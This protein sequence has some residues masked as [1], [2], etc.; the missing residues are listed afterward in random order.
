[1][2]VRDALGPAA[3]V[4]DLRLLASDIDTD[5]LGRA[6]DGVY[7]E[8][9]TA[10]IPSGLRTRYV[11]RG[12]GG[13]AGLVCIRPEIRALVTFRR[14]NLMDE[15]WPIQTTFD[16]IFC[17]NVLIYF[18]RRTQRRLIDRL[19][20]FLGEDGLLFLG[21]SE[22]LHGMC[23][24]MQHVANTIYQRRGACDDGHHPDHR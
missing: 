12:R 16:A 1:M 9:R 11:L 20:G 5:T 6:L 24:G 15:P 17:R 18:D 8:E 7:P 19:R 2:V 23:A 10:S 14:L 3:P 21:H 4:W 22:S 13:Q